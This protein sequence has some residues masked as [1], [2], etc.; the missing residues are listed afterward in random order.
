MN[1]VSRTTQSVKNAGVNVFF[2]T[3]QLVVGFWSRKVFYD[4]LG[5]EVLGLDTTAQSLLEFLNIAESGVGTAVA[6]F[7]YAPL[8]NKDTL[9]IND[10]V[11]LQG[12]IYRRVA[13]LILVVSLLLMLFFPLIFSNITVPL[14]YA[15]ATF[16]VLLFG[17]LL[18]Y[19]VN[20]RQSLLAAD[21][22]QYKVTKATQTSN[23]VLKVALILYLP[24]STHPFLFYL[25]TTMVG[26]VAGSVWLNHVIS[27]DYPWLKPS[28]M[29]GKELLKKYP[30]VFEKTRQL[31]VHK[32]AG[33][34]VLYCTPLIMYSFSSLTIVAYYGN[35]LA[36]IDKSKALMNHAF[37][38][39]AAGVGNLIASSDYERMSKVFWELT[40]SRFF[41][42]TSLV[43]V[44]AL[45]TEPFI[46]LWL[47][48]TYLLGKPLLLLILANAWLYLNRSVIDSYKDGFGLFSDV[49]APIAEGAVNL[50]VSVIGGFL[51][52]IEGVLLGSIVSYVVIVYGWKPYYLFTNGLRK[53][54]VKE[55]LC[56]YLRRLAIVLVFAT[57]LYI[58]LS[59][60]LPSADNFWELTVHAI[61]TTVVVVAYMYIILYLFTDGMKS[62]HRRIVGIVKS[63]IKI[64]KR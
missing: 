23:I 36:I 31:F 22:K 5:S 41:M 63:K 33:F 47:S 26:Y 46:S 20:Y 13:T 43:V 51:W 62:F 18:G 24:Y 3:I 61:T 48:P 58:T 32:I 40:D 64:E 57:I 16:T 60:A 56:P 49:W 10:I 19:Y 21:Q 53:S 25:A 55:F 59:Y 12:W 15:Y 11:T 45:I 17:N 7:L 6:Y 44:L 52:G 34:V 54:Y 39:T 50:S 1:E 28:K 42:S 4:Y 8:Y 30:D 2:F 29:S 35:Y 9:T 38:G 37:S 27:R 14:W